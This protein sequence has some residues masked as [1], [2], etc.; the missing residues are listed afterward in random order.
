MYRAFF[1]T[2]AQKNDAND[3]AFL[4]D[5][6]VKQVRE[7]LLEKRLKDQSNVDPLPIRVTPPLA[8]W[9][10]LDLSDR[11]VMYG[12]LAVGVALLA[13]VCTRMACLAGAG[14]LLM[15]FLAMPPLP[16]WPDN[17]KAEGHYLYINKNFVEMLA[18]L[19][20]A[21]T[22]QRPLVRHRRTAAIDVPEVL[23]AKE[24]GMR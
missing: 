17:P 24:T 10:L 8:Q 3:Q 21:T 2:M 11:I 4:K 14:F 6:L 5:P 23:L 12:V 13:G 20:L 7:D 19:A 18:L 9:T 22:A 16:G 1:F 15:F